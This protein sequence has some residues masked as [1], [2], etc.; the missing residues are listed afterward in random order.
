MKTIRRFALS[1]LVLGAAPAAWA[2][3]DGLLQASFAAAFAHPFTGLDHALVMVGIGLWAA[4]QGGVRTWQIPAAFVVTMLFAAFA[5]PALLTGDWVERALVA[6]VVATGL[7]LAVERRLA[8]AGA[9]AAGALLAVAHGLAHGVELPLAARPSL[10]FAFA[11]ATALLHGLGVL[12]AP[13]VGPGGVRRIG[14]AT[15]LGAT[16][17]ALLG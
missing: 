5:A 11:A 9:I 14:L 3:P 4:R 12:C 13:L 6:S 8:P 17:W 2:H 1:V 15:A 7:L 10:G 16:G